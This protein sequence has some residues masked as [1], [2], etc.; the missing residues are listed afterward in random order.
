MGRDWRV[1]EHAFFFSLKTHRL[2][3]YDIG[4]GLSFTFTLLE[5]M[6]LAVQVAA[7]RHICFLHCLAAGVVTA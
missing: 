6:L 2:R 1:G 7:R 4:Q 3:L 5:G